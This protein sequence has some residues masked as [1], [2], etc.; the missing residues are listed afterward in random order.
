MTPPGEKFMIPAIIV[1]KTCCCSGHHGL[2]QPPAHLTPSPWWEPPKE[3]LWKLHTESGLSGNL[4][5][6]VQTWMDKAHI[7]TGVPWFPLLSRTL[8]SFANFS[9]AAQGEVG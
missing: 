4:Q 5:L 7:E 1:H 2:C 6:H 3:A 8:P 9:C